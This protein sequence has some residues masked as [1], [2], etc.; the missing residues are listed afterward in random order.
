MAVM[1]PGYGTHFLTTKL[2]QLVNWSRNSSL[3]PLL[4]GLSCCAIEMMATGASRFDL[5][6]FGVIFRASPRQSD[7]LI[8]AGTLTKKMAPILKNLWDQMP[9]PK[10]C[11]SMGVCAT[12]GG[13]F[14]S[15]SVVQGVDRVLPVH[16]YTLGCPPRP[17]TLI[18]AIMELKE[19]IKQEKPISEGK[20]I[21][22]LVN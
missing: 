11:I 21:A 12:H 14:D 1:T 6:R 22:E 17:E 16:V 15:Y 10:W 4:C 20:K 9:D 3:W 2:D 7:V 5:D 13:I 8:V 19:K 18:H